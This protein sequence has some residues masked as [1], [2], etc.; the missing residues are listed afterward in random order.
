M[1]WSWF[2]TVGL[3]VL[4]AAG[5]LGCDSSETMGDP[6]CPNDPVEGPVAESCG[7]WVSA[8]QGDDANNGTQ[9]APVASLM[10]A[11]E[12]AAK[13]PHRVYACGET[14]TEV[15]MVP[16]GV[17]LHGGFDCERGWAYTGETARAKL[18][19]TGPTAVTWF[20]GDTQRRAYFMDFHVKSADATEPSGSSIAVFV[21]DW[22]PLSIVRAELV[23][24]NGA[25]GLDGEP[26]VEDDLPAMAG[27]PGNDGADAC[28]APVSKGGAPAETACAEATSTGGKGGDSGVAFAEDGAKGEPESAFPGGKGGLGQQGPAGCTA[29]AQGGEG[30]PGDGGYG[31][32]YEEYLTPEGF[33]GAA[34][35]DGLPGMPG[36]GGGGGGAVLGSV[37]VCGGT[38]P[39]GAAGG[40][41]GAGGCG[42]KPGKGGRPGGASIALAT[43]SDGELRTEYVVFRSGIG[44]KGGDGGASQLG[45][46]GGAG[47]LGGKG[48]GTIPAGCPGGAGGKGGRGGIGGGGKGGHAAS[49]IGLLGNS[50]TV[51]IFD[52][53]YPGTPG[54][55]GKG[56]PA[57]PGGDGDSGYYSTEVLVDP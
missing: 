8:G 57:L 35:E 41:G 22:M 17:S 48:F 42:G 13:G 4:A 46:K 10:R 45:G 12:L 31:G 50:G 33:K 56:D 2:R 23:A 11:I 29:G 14:W 26:A 38:F 7:I 43:R 20:A 34:G 55:G 39:G 6:P 47:G 54:I 40:S 16:S 21:R 24:G 30:V 25:D 1:A 49:I 27:A 28:S 51:R 32:D 44:G 9:A 18:L 19:S 5:G 3:V 53:Y 52:E 37:A 36:Q 15:V